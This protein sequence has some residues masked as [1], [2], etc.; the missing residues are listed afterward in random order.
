MSEGYP[1]EAEIKQQRT[2]KPI[3][4]FLVGLFVLLALGVGIVLGFVGKQAIETR[5]QQGIV[6]NTGLPEDLSY[7]EVETVYDSLRTNFDGEL[8]HD[9]LIEGLKDG[10]VRASG[11]P[12]TEY[13]DKEEA[14]SFEESLNGSF[15]GIGAQ[16][17]K[18][19]Q[20]VVIVSPL[21]GFP[22]EAAGLMPKDII[23]EI[24]GENAY[25][26]SISEAVKKIRGP[27][28]TVV[29][30][31]IIRNETE[32]IEV[33][34]TRDEI[35]IP[36]VEYE[37]RDDHIGYLKISRFG[38]D[39]K[40][41]VQRAAKAFVDQNVTGIIV[42]VR[43]NPGGLLNASVEVASLWIEEGEVVVEQRQS[44]ETI[45][46]QRARGNAL[47]GTIPTVVLINE[48]SASASEILAGALHDYGKATLIGEK[49]YGKGSVQRLIEFGDGS[50]LKVTIARW[51]TPQGRNI[52][53]EGI[54]P[55]QTVERT[56][57]D[58][59]AERDPQL[60]TAVKQL[61]D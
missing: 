59:E 40:G 9:E 43:G 48:G 53:E 16:L 52:D 31:T 57:E 12:Y 3:R 11:D 2:L 4:G 6:R 44:G 1:K 54:E 33:E 20:S 13:F 49:S 41:L 61:K 56:I 36:S 8:S 30:L 26:I 32:R 55:D 10:L 45:D 14:A 39:T 46:T 24:N 15:T 38:T 7:A 58:F 42:D 19:G 60:D 22:A 23:A 37:V 21:S 50:E 34:I 47:L 17:G 29:K 28:G 5:L 18:E 27:K 51:F 25:D 35:T